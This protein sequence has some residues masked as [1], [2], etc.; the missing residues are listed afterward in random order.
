MR[1]ETMLREVQACLDF[2][3]DLGADECRL[4]CRAS[5]MQSEC[6]LDGI[7]TNH[8]HIGS[9]V[10]VTKVHGLI[11]R[12]YHCPVCHQPTF[13][14]WQVQFTGPLRTHRCSACNSR[15]SVPWLLPSAFGGLAVIATGLGGFGALW[16]LGALGFSGDP[17]VPFV[18]GTIVSPLPVLLLYGKLIYL[19]E[20]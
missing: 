15:V 2:L 17:T 7:D 5:A 13:S 10:G 18:I 14:F 4:A 9:S 12:N 16:L 1:F 19:V 3:A 11:M 6:V 20:A 8:E